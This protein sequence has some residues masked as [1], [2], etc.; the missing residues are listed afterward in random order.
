MSYSLMICVEKYVF[1]T[2]LFERELVLSGGFVHPL[3]TELAGS[4]TD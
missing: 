2:A 4:E 3:Q 1:I